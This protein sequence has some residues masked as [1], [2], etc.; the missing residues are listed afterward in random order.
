MKLSRDENISILGHIISF[1]R[2]NCD[3]Y[4]EMSQERQEGV[5][6]EFK[7]QFQL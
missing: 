6:E 4:Q 5:R 2:Q 7:R 3:D 1:I